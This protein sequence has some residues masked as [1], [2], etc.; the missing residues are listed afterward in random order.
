M[1]M[2]KKE[3]RQKQALKLV[4][5]LNS[6]WA[7]DP[8]CQ[9]LEH[10]IRCG[11]KRFFVLRDDIS[12]RS[13]ANVFRRILDCVNTVEYCRRKD[14]TYKEGKRWLPIEQELK[15][16][17]KQDWD[18]PDYF[19]KYFRL[20]DVNLA[21][22]VVRNLVYVFSPT[23]CFDFKVKPHYLTHVSFPDPVIASRKAEIEKVLD[24]GG[25]RQYFK[26]KGIWVNYDLGWTDN[27]LFARRSKTQE[28]FKRQVKE[29]SE[30]ED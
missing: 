1:K 20:V 3:E 7:V 22:T 27:L 2:H 26:S 29:Y 19:K 9:E 12:R 10:P 13:D 30:S 16:I 23:Y 15:N 24:R 25:W 17:R 18:F 14:F 5:E 8:P 4:R 21:T 28:D 11:W 6:L